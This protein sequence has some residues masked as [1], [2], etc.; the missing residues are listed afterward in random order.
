[1]TPA[2]WHFPAVEP[3]VPVPHEALSQS[4]S[5]WQVV[6]APTLQ[7]PAAEPFVPVPQEPLSQSE[8]AWQA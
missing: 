1:M 4:V 2:S 5:A 8:L 7:V 3:F 6:L